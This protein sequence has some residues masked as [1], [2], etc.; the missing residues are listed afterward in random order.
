VNDNLNFE[1]EGVLVPIE[2]NNNKHIRIILDTSKNDPEA[3]YVILMSYIKNMHIYVDRVMLV[4]TSSGYPRYRN[5]TYIKYFTYIDFK[6]WLIKHTKPESRTRDT[7]LLSENPQQTI[8][9]TIAIKT[10]KQITNY[11]QPISIKSEK[12]IK[13][14]QELNTQNQWNLQDLL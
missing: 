7:E 4:N 9:L 3:L 5:V 2:T 10:L 1:S 11:T 8:T 12:I 6:I 13:E 14:M